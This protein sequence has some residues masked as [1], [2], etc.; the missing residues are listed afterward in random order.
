MLEIRVKSE[1]LSLVT[2]AQISIYRLTVH[3]SGAPPS[4][5]CHRQK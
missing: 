3:Y 4:V 1:L 2:S 5:H